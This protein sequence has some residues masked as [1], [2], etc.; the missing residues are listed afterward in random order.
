MVHWEGLELR[1]DGHPDWQLRLAWD[2]DGARLSPSGWPKGTH[3]VVGPTS[4]EESAALHAAVPVF[5]WLGGVPVFHQDV[6]AGR[7]FPPDVA[8]PTNVPLAIELPDGAVVKTTLPGGTTSPLVVDAVMEHAVKNGLVF[9]GEANAPAVH[10][11]YFLDPA[12]S[13]VVLGPGATLADVDWI[14]VVANAVGPGD[15]VRCTF[16]GGKR[17]PLEK[18]TWTITLQSRRTRA[19]ID[20]KV[21]PPA[22]GCPMVALDE[23]ALATPARDVVFAWITSVAGTR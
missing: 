18:V 22:P 13:D 9:E 4:V 17:Y 16:A 19:K 6:D 8:M 5:P 10:T 23:R 14:A 2:P 1:T 21:F 12:S 3:F 7:F 15:G 20:E 11:V